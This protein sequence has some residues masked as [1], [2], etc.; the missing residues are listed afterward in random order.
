L[1]GQQTDFI[2]L[3]PAPANFIVRPSV[4]QLSVLHAQCGFH[5]ARQDQQCS[6]RAVLRLAAHPG[7]Q[8][9]EQL[10]NVQCVATGG[11]GLILDG[12]MIGKPIT[13]T[14]LQQSLHAVLS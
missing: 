13:T 12:R 9:F 14:Q 4:P 5:L 11:A 3:G 2:A 6:S 7:P 10:L 1:A 8:Q